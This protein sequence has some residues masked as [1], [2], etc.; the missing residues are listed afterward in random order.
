MHT[1]FCPEDSRRRMILREVLG[2]DNRI[3]LLLYETDRIEKEKIRAGT[4]SKVIS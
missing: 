3:L 4:D 2:R 1:E